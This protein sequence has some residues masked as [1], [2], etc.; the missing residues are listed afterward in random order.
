MFSRAEGRCDR[1]NAD[2]EHDWPELHMLGWAPHTA[3]NLDG[4]PVLCPPCALEP[5]RASTTTAGLP[6]PRDWQAQGLDA[7]LDRIFRTGVAT[8]HAAPGA[9]KTL[10]AGM[11][12]RWLKAA[13]LV[14]RLV[15]VVPNR[16]LVRQWAD[17]LNGIKIPLDYEPRDGYEE[18]RDT[19]G[20]VVT[21][22]SL[23]RAAKGHEAR[24]NAAPTLV[25][26]DEV[27]HVADKRGWGDAVVRTIGDVTAGS[28]HA[29]GVLNM[30]GTLFRSTGDNRIGTVRYERVDVDGVAKF[31]AQADYSVPASRLIG[32]ELRRPDLY[33]YT[34]QV[35]LVDLVHETTI[36]GDIADLEDQS[37][38]NAAIRGAFESHSWAEKFAS[39]GLK[40]L[41]QQLATIDNRAPLKLLY[42][43]QDIKTARI[44]ADAINKVAGKDFARLVTSDNKKALDTLRKAAKEPKPCAIVAVRM[45]TEGF[46]CP[47]VSVIA[48]ASTISAVLFVA[49]MMARAMRV[50]A[51]ERADG[52]MLPAQILI[53]NNPVLRS[54]FATAL[55]G[56]FH[57]L[58]VP[59]DDDRI[60]VADREGADSGTPRLPRYDLVEMS[61]AMLRTATV[62][63]EPD[64]EVDADELDRVL[65]LC[66]Q[67]G[68]PEPY[69]PRV[70][71]VARRAQAAAPIYTR[72]DTIPV[73]V[74]PTDPR[75]LNKALRERIKVAAQWMA[76]HQAHDST[77]PNVQIF[78]G[79][80]NDAAGIPAGGRDKATPEQL[81]KCGAWMV[82]QVKAHCKALDEP[83]PQWALDE[84]ER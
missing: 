52:R 84:V 7:V 6:Q 34:G 66:V 19:L 18:I 8:L 49:Q 17:S 36:T 64:G 59:T 61:E 50:T 65:E 79:K 16:A 62:L 81:R 30:T 23:A 55:I 28:V 68:I 83:Y 70:A 75:T 3:R 72:T 76:V 10:F 14:S 4:V 46:D 21:Y 32:V 53:P 24:M 51:T 77:Y 82:A 1:C 69:A 73:S 2:L 40:M 45:V 74:E 33:A 60:R 11:V 58:D 48:Y 63:G 13:G 43:A 25:V 31:Q 35:E 29:S 22:Q 39:E 42:V 78:Q 41:S 20:L 67:M 47:E 12:F 26:L 80:A 38:T 9:G 27:H 37:Q 71:V 56:H 44:A 15:I 54:A 5:G 57:I